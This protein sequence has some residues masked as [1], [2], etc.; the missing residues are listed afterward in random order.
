MRG[1]GENELVITNY[2]GT[3]TEVTIPKTMG[4]G[5]VTAIGNGAFAGASG[6]CGGI[7]TSYA[8][9]ENMKVHQRIT[10]LVLPESVNYIGVGAFADMLELTEIN[11]PM[12]VVE[13]GDAAFYNCIALGELVIPK[14]VRCIGKHAFNH[15]H[16][17]TVICEKKS[18][19]EEYCRATGI[20]YK[21][22]ERL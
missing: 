21:F 5:T 7:V 19:A 11:I 4:K 8:S 13:I 9:Y 10:K 14:T 1:I 17:L 12:G 22:K 18:F 20:K 2:K 6:L 15:C 16:K 3:A